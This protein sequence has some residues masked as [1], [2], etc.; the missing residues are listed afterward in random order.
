MYEVT[1]REFDGQWLVWALFFDPSLVPELDL[2]VLANRAYVP[3][4]WVL[5]SVEKT[6]EKAYAFMNNHAKNHRPPLVLDSV[7]RPLSKSEKR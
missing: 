5:I 1:K 3:S 7:A 4:R 6:K 2:S